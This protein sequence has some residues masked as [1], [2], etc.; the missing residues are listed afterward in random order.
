MSIN[1]TVRPSGA[2]SGGDSRTIEGEGAI[3]TRAEAEAALTLLP[4]GSTNVVV[5][6]DR[7]YTREQLIEIR[8]R[9][10][11][12]AAPVA[13]DRGT[14]AADGMAN[15]V[16]LQGYYG[17]GVG[18]NPHDGGGARLS[19]VPSWR[20][21]G[22]EHT[23]HFDLPVG[24]DIGH[25]SMGYTLPGGGDANSAFT[26]YGLRVAPTARW[27][28]P[29]ADRRL[30]LSLGLG[31]GVGGFTTADSTMVS[32]P[33]TCT[34]GDFGRGECE[35]DAGPRTGNGGTTGLFNPRIGN[36]R[37]TSGAYFDIGLPLTFG[38]NF[39]RGDWGNV[40]GFLSFEPA[41]THMMPGDGDGFGFWS[42]RGGLGIRGTF[43]GS[44]V[45]R[46]RRPAGPT[47]EDAR[48]HSTE[49]PGGAAFTL[50]DDA[51]VRTLG[52]L[53]ANARILGVQLDDHPEDTSAP[54]TFDAAWMTPGAH[55]IKIR[56]RNPGDTEDRIRPVNITVGT[57]APVS[58][59]EGG[60]GEAFGLV[61]D[62]PSTATRPA[63]DVVGGVSTPRPVRVGRIT[64]TSSFPEGATYQIYVD[65]NPVGSA[66]DL[67]RDRAT[68]LTVPAT[69]G[70]GDHQIEVRVSRPGMAEIRYP[71]RAVRV[72]P[73]V[74][75]LS[76][77]SVPSNPPS[78]GHYYNDPI[79]VT[80]T[81]DVATR[82]RI[83]VGSHTE[84]VNLVVGV[85]TI[86]MTGA[87]R[88]WTTGGA[89]GRSTQTVRIQPLDAAGALTG[90]AV[91]AGS[92]VIR[93]AGGGHRRSPT[94]TRPARPLP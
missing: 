59:P 41:Y 40:G 11:A 42:M 8:D 81:S 47:I 64:T 10:P 67:P 92:V 63:P 38:V 35:P 14:T 87:P 19:W 88:T 51:A 20:A 48:T 6:G 65:S 4:E 60:T 13:A 1:I 31:L 58:V 34:P 74:A 33:T 90:T 66:A 76:A 3:D 23:L 39:A 17:G 69:I 61:L 83:T 78:G 72:G 52:G 18:S 55:T 15:G 49:I 43:G 82:A 84:D 93:R 27:V 5:A 86:T 91:E 25:F 46:P 89:A 44:S 29:W 77:A 73:G 16:E 75:T 37:G 68:E 62:M 50:A 7:T 54:Y 94:T 21:A 30:S 24:L 22:D 12:A 45:E 2:T 28:P 36:S 80:V 71:A 57:P 32:V 56:Y 70:D 79:R 26:R 53:G 85:N 9:A